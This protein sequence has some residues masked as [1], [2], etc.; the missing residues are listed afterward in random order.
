MS[1]K[2]VPI[3]LPTSQV[4]LALVALYVL[5]HLHTGTPLPVDQL[6]ADAQRFFAIHRPVDLAGVGI[7]CDDLF[8]ALYDARLTP[9]DRLRIAN[10]DPDTTSDDEAAA[11]I[12]DIEA[13]YGPIT[14]DDLDRAYAS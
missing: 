2:L 11:I 7:V 3:D 4:E 1:E 6:V 12:R 9:A 13:R 14:P 10:I 5:D 8:N